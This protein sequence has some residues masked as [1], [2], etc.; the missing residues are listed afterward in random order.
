MSANV[1]QSIPDELFPPPD[2]VKYL[3]STVLNTY[4]LEILCYAAYTVVY[5]LSMR[6]ILF[7]GSSKAQVR[8]KA[9]AS[10]I[11]ILWAVL[12]MRVGCV[13]HFINAVYLEH[14]ETRET[15]FIWMFGPPGLL[16]IRQ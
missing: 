12:T 5:F 4:V 13:W 16:F 8:R 15:E 14:G 7:S 9:L 10:T 3:L 1:T 11:T 2:V 6:Q